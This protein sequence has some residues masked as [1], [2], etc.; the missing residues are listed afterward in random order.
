MSVKKIGLFVLV[1]FIIGSIDSLR[2]MPAAALFGP[3]LVFFFI[4]AAITFL[5]PIALISAELSSYHGDKNG[6]YEWTKEAFGPKTAFFTIWL[7]WINT[8]IWFPTILAFIAGGLAFLI[9][10]HLAQDKW[11]VVT[12]ILVAFWSMTLL[13]L[14]DMSLSAKFAAFAAIFGFVLPLLVLIVLLVIWLV[15][16]DPVQ[17]HF[18][19]TNILPDFSKI[20]NW[21]S[22]TAV[23]TAFLGVELAAV[24]VKDM[25][26]PRKQYPLGVLIASGIILLTMILGSLAI[27][28]V[29]PNKQIGLISGI[30]QTLNYF[31]DHF[32]LKTFAVIICGLIVFATLGQMINWIESPAR[33]LQQAAQSGSLP[34]ILG[35]EN[36]H[37]MPGKVL[38]L[39]GVIVTFVCLAFVFIPSINDVYWLLTDLST[40]LYLFMYVLMF[41]SALV[42]H[43]KHKHIKK[44][45]TLKGGAFTK[46]CLC[47]LGIL[48]CGLTIIV[49][50]IPPSQIGFGSIGNYALIFGSGL[51]VLM[52][53]AV[54]L[55]LFYKSTPEEKL[56]P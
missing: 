55:A 27:A 21:V 3:S 47:V 22:L 5:L 29:I 49:G 52:I 6:V 14:R 30:F 1:L 9:N 36:K 16:G 18:H 4:A 35:Q 44:G 24:N 51:I 40:E 26:N 46:W 11:Y 23:V 41:I 7:Q 8:T 39:Q 25:K 43:Y 48:S 13:S 15:N 56:L 33:G 54:L 20:N 37:G 34:K 45:F 53:P 38:V 19:M 50:F 32:H 17:I 10:P 42:L 2:N 28:F 12:V 31:L